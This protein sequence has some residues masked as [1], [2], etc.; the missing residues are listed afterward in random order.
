MCLTQAKMVKMEKRSTR[1][2]FERKEVQDMNN[3]TLPKK[4]NN[5]NINKYSI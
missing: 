4:M 1:H 5:H 3:Y 2:F